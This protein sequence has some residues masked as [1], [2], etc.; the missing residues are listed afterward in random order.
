[1][2]ESRDVIIMTQTVLTF[3]SQVK[4][5][6]TGEL[7]K[8]FRVIQDDPETN[9]LI[10]FRSLE[11][12]HFA[13]LV[14]HQ[15]QD[16]GP[17]LIF[18]NNV[19]G[20]LDE[21]LKDLSVCSSG[22]HQ[23]YSCCKDYTITG[24][25][26][27]QG[28]VAYLR[29]HAV[30]PNAYHIGNTGR[31]LK[32]ILQEQTLRGVLE[33]QANG[34]AQSGQVTPSALL[35][36]F[37]SF[38]RAKP[39]FAWVPGVG[40]RQ[41]FLEWLV[42][43]VRLVLVPVIPLVTIVLVWQFLPHAVTGWMLALLAV[44]VLVAG[45]VL[46]FKESNDPVQ[47]YPANSENLRKLVQ[48]EDRTHSVQNHMASITLVKPGWF[49]RVTLRAVLWIVNLL[50]RAKATHGELSHIPSI[51]FAHWS[52]IDNGRRLLFLSNF[53]GSWENYL[54]DFID[55]ASDGLTAIWSNTVN[56]PRTT[57]LVGGGARD[58]PRFKAVA[59]DSQTVTNAW[60]SAYRNLTVH[61]IDNNS[62]IREDIY[63]PLDQDATK[64]WL[65][66]L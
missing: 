53:D 36:T 16:Y 9:A 48:S 6:K 11:S 7:G 19:D 62:S 57:L 29:A 45:G 24:A 56:F 5:E 22:L 33:T 26:D 47:Q 35:E 27:R 37:Q 59:R 44:L 38:V 3:I 63:K 42:P 30:R 23:I 43:C 51:H 50:A 64:T 34:L 14:L 1:M 49:R 21:Y 28:L 2:P 12:L 40:P 46:R 66:R 18:E 10:L 61:G 17:Y 65:S 25:S 20:T 60:Y 13:S 39:E 58:G 31:S 52:V 4:S 54:D 55:K 41:T 8:L 32:R 15:S